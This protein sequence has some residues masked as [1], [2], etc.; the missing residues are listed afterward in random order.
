LNKCGSSISILICCSLLGCDAV[1]FG[2]YCHVIDYI[3]GVDW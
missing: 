1:S 2:K 3:R